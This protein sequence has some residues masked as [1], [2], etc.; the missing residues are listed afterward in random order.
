[1]TTSDSRRLDEDK[2]DF[3]ALWR[4]AWSYKYLIV[5]VTVAS[6]LAAAIVAFTTTP[7]FRA[8]AAITEASGENLQGAAAQLSSQLGGIASLVGVDLGGVGNRSREI[9]GFLKSRQLVEDFVKRYEL[10]SKLFPA[11]K[12]PPTLWFAVRQFQNGVLSIRDDKRTGLTRVSVNW[13]DP[14]VAARWAN[15][16]VALANELLRTKAMN[17]AKASV[18]Y[19]NNQVAQTNVVE[20]QRVMYNLIESETKTLMLANARAEYAFTVVDPAIAPEVRSS[21]QRMLLILLGMVLGPILG[22]L[23]ALA[24]SRLVT[25]RR[26][27]RNE[28]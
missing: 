17:E 6:T 19:L 25:G 24:H 9:Q 22:T 26:A 4:L 12:R 27:A 3:V 7:S 8:E 28:A 13:T 14:V 2:I 16:F 20:I 5:L 15:D 21:P 23:A 18:V 10:Q 11:A 1:V